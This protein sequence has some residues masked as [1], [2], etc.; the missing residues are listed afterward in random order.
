MRAGLDA[1][2]ELWAAIRR[3]AGGRAAEHV[4]ILRRQRSELR[5]AASVGWEG[6]CRPLGNEGNAADEQLRAISKRDAGVGEAR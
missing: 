1:K 2:L 3:E 4:T 5:G 6:E